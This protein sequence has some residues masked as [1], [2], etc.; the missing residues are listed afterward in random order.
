[1][2]AWDA[3]LEY[4][5]DDVDRVLV[6]GELLEGWLLYRHN[7]DFRSTYQPVVSPLNRLT[8]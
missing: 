8:E 5:S 1:M 3:L 6:A 2:R 7:A 4:F